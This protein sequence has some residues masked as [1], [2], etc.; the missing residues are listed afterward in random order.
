MKTAEAARGK[1]AG[2][3]INFGLDESFLKDRHGPCPLCGGTN[4]FRF[5]N[6]DGNGSWIC[7]QCGAGSGIKL[8]MD[9]KGWDF[10]TAAAEIDKIVG[11]VQVS[12]AIRASDPARRIKLITDRLQGCSEHVR[13]YLIGRNLKPCKGIKSARV[14]YYDDGV[15]QGDYDCMVLPIQNRAGAVIS[16][17]ITYLQNAQKASVRSP[18]KM[19]PP[20]ESM[21]GAAI[22]LTD[23]Y[24][25]IGLAEGIETALAVMET[26]KI[27]CWA[28]SCAN[29]M[30]TF[31]PPEGVTSVLIYA[32]N[33]LNFTGQKAAYV[34]ANRLA[35]QGL[36]TG[37]FIPNEVGDFADTMKEASSQ[38]QAA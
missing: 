10:K 9:F 19:L 33:D 36:T 8:L 1:W 13:Q 2:I 26:Y 11:N 18:K 7:N 31:Q 35:I 6:K 25:V 24:P 14:E 5:D 16:Y 4:R 37:V 30:E 23:I 12:A 17:H 32:D 27:P 22:R 20:S 34:L 21:Q 29:M 28:A 3:L 15:L 38:E